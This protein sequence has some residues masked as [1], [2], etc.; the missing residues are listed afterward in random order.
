MGENEMDLTSGIMPL[1]SF[2]TIE[3]L[4]PVE[5][6]STAPKI[7][8]AGAG[9]LFETMLK[10]ATTMINE[11][12]AYE[13][14]AKEAEMAYAMGLTNSTADLQV[15]QTKALVSLQ[16]TVAVRNAVIDAYKEIMQIQF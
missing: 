9:D 5:N 2:S 16:Y 1:G 14:S 4:K 15:A 8:E 13:Q 7:G 6:K 12:N 3:A 11:T 10:S